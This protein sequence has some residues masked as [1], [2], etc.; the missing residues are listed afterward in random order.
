MENH[1]HKSEEWIVKKNLINFAND[2]KYWKTLRNLK[3]FSAK[4][5]K[6]TSIILSTKSSNCNSCLMYLKMGWLFNH[7]CPG[8]KRI[9]I[10]SHFCTLITRKLLI[11]K[12]FLISRKKILIF[13]Q[14]LRFQA[15]PSIW[16]WFTSIGKIAKRV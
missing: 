9:I 8:T 11:N 14:A 13:S 4:T 12:N 10:Y 1:I 16:V 15:Q 3:Y 6:T 2:E 5:T 7:N